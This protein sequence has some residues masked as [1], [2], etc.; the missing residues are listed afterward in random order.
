[1]YLLHFFHLVIIQK[2]TTNYSSFHLLSMA[3]SDHHFTAGKTS[4]T[5]YSSKL[6]PSKSSIT[7]GQEYSYF[8]D[9]H[10]YFYSP[11]FSQNKHTVESQN[12]QAST[13]YV[14]ST[15]IPA[16]K[17]ATTQLEN[18]MEED[19]IHRVYLTKTLPQLNTD[20]LMNR[21][22]ESMLRH[23][24]YFS[25]DTS[26]ADQALF[27]PYFGNEQKVDES[28][29]EEDYNH[30]LLSDLLSKH[31]YYTS[32]LDKKDPQENLQRLNNSFIDRQANFS[33]VD[34]GAPL[35]NSAQYL[36]KLPSVN[37]CYQI[38]GDRSYTGP[39]LNETFS[40][41]LEKNQPQTNLPES[42]ETDK[43]WTEVEKKINK[44]LEAV[45]NQ[46]SYILPQIIEK[47]E[48]ETPTSPTETTAGSLTSIKDESIFPE[49]S[50]DINSPLIA[51]LK[52]ITT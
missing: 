2:I 24:G 22:D 45:S 4:D 18:F 3:S 8:G 34:F 16:A 32:L 6:D 28:Y 25:F 7:T 10:S 14:Y 31:D 19:E 48:K 44:I 41:S 27:T 5:L 49:I 50:L 20:R 39:F 12:F 15:H 36:S 26:Q 33:S 35:Y 11:I 42:N 43:N 40:S 51:E 17:L 46:S 23:D 30:N 37:D 21:K 9:P 38:I 13:S 47:L 1:M 29:R 52:G